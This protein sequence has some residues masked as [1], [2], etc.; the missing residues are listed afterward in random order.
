VAEHYTHSGWIVA[1]TVESVHFSRPE[2]VEF[3]L[4]R[5]PVPHVLEHFE[6]HEV[7][8]GT[9]LHYAGELGTDLWALGRLW[10]RSVGDTW[11]ATVQD[12]LNSIR[13]E[14]ERRAR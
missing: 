13:A 9:E 7:E 2:R 4:V 1:T 10:G 3:R 12:S 8:G 5:G 6:L 11:E 14:A